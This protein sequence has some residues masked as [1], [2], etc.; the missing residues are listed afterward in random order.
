MHQ[1][2]DFLNK[3][4]FDGLDLDW[5]Y[6][7]AADRDGNPEDKQG[8]LDLI[9]ELRVAFDDVGKDWLL[10]AAV[11]MTKSKLADGYDVPGLCQALDAVHGVYENINVEDGLQLWVDEGC[12]ANKLVVGIPFYGRSYV[13]SSSSEHDIGAPIDTA[14]G[15]A[16]P[17][18]YTDSRGVWAY[19]EIC[20]KLKDEEG[21]I[22]KWDKDGKVP[23]A[24][25]ENQWVGYDDPQSVKRKM[26]F[27]KENGYLGAMTWS[28]DMDD[29]RGLCGKANPLISIMHSK[30]KS[31]TVP[32]PNED[33]YLEK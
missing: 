17:A 25:R 15:G 21:W 18:P 31:Y 29:F 26:E 9:N 11:P 28:I 20:S 19:F 12:P 24:Y 30:M 4:D 23:Y 14:A 1:T 3:Y 5:E 8:F 16:D 10:T 13:L 22:R 32:E 33:N 2:S 7:G 6:P 27:I